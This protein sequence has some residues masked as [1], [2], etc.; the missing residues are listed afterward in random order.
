MI[1]TVRLENIGDY[2]AQVVQ[3]HRLRY[4]TFAERLQWEVQTTGEMEFDVYDAMSPTYLLKISEDGSVRGC[5][6][7]LPTTGPYMLKEVFPVLLGGQPAPVDPTIYEISRFAVDPACQSDVRSG[8]IAS[9]THELFQGFIEHGLEIGLTEFI[10]VVDDRME[11][12]VKRA[13]LTWQRVGDPYQIGAAK[14]VA[15]LIEVSEDAL[16]RLRARSGIT[17]SVL[18]HPDNIHVAA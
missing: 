5:V 14:S 8:G 4:R 15:G 13:G 17:R 2:S 7:L 16:A 12:I 18:H 3:M 6:R 1:H 9:T 11:V 10:A